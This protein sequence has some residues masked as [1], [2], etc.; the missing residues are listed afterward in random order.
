MT[1]TALN[2]LFTI[3]PLGEALAAGELIVTS[4]SRLSRSIGAAWQRQCADGGLATWTAP[5]VLPL[6]SWLQECWLTLVDGAYP[7]A[8]TGVPVSP[9]QEALIWEQVIAADPELPPLANAANYTELARR[10]WQLVGQWQVAEATLASSLHSGSRHLLAW[11]RAVA[12]QLASQGLISAE[13]RTAIV[14]RGFRDGVLAPEPRL[15]LVGFQTLSPLVEQVLAA[16]AGEVLYHQPPAVPGAATRFSTDTLGE[17]IAAA[18]RWARARAAADPAARIGIVIPSLTAAQTSVE[19]IFRDQFDPAWCLPA[20]HYSPPPY[21]ISAA[22]PLAEAP[23]VA[24]ALK[25]LALSKAEL[26]SSD[27]CTLLN[28]PFWGDAEREGELRSR[29]QAAL[30]DLGLHTYHGA[31]FR[32]LLHREETGLAL[33]DGGANL[34]H[35]LSAV[36][37]LF[38]GQPRKA[39]FRHWREVFCQA[40]DSL[41]WPGTR[42]IDSLE[43]QQLQQWWQLLDDFV[44]LERVAPAVGSQ[45]ALHRLT[46]L[47]GDTLFH[48][49][50]EDTQVQILGRLEAAGLAFDHL[51]VMNMDD[52]HWPEA[53]TPHPLLPVALQRQL[54][55]PRACPET[56]LALSRELF[57]LFRGSA[58]EV[59]FSHA[60]RDGDVDL[61]PSTLLEGLPATDPSPAGEPCRG[62]PWWPTIAASAALELVED[63]SGPAFNPPQGKVSGG[64]RLL[65][66]QASCP[67]NAFA[68]WRLGAEP[69]GAPQTGLGAALRGI[70]VH[71]SLERF[72]RET[73]DLEGLL[74]LTEEQRSARLAQ[75]ID[76][77]IGDA[78]NRQQG[79]LK[80]E[81]FG[82]RL[83]ALE[84]QRLVRML[85]AWLA[86]ESERPPF[87]VEGSE[88]GGELDLGGLRI[89]LR[90]DRIDRLG[91]GRTAIIDYK[92][93]RASLAGIDGERLTQP[94]L[95]LY[96]LAAEETPGAIAYALIS[97]RQLAID[98]LADS[99]R[100]LPGCVTLAA[101]GLPESWPETIALW[102]RGLED[103]AAELRAGRADVTFYSRDALTWGGHLEPLNRL[104][105]LERLEAFRQQPQEHQR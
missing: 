60:R 6:E 90:L 51:W 24:A 27:F 102:R 37:T 41:G 74:A 59:V 38:R 72:W 25:L 5:R 73:R 36:A 67:F 18:A 3:A 78:F 91:D 46:A 62:H 40:L 35:R 100:L 69:L 53:P 31:R 2:P 66:D 99:D 81:D 45:E 93:G 94:Q 80:R 9:A 61:Q 43:F 22:R 49:E 44:L 98:G 84:A 87:V 11:G 33:G 103:L 58:R 52:R 83:L 105:G 92:T 7:P 28:N 14:L 16:A 65:A 23:V 96:A 10:G 76:A 21:N 42:A 20:S 104:P 63:S 8:L 70:L 17:E 77:A 13:Q 29:C 64:S 4:N 101:K 1:G 79:L 50:G 95:P 55:M 75:A 97:R 89:F 30:L 54:A 19:R 88:V 12:K 48:A 82:E 56:E 34:S 39:G 68:R 32:Q 15:H 86:V 71:G 26:A 57:A 47:A 85:D